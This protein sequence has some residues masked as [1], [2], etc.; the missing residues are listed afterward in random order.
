VGGKESNQGQAS[1]EICL[2]GLRL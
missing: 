1:S 2:Y